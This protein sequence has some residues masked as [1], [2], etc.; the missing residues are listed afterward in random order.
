[1]I[2]LDGEPCAL[3][4][5][6]DITDAKQ[7]EKARDASEER[8]RLAQQVARIGTFE[9]DIQTGVNTWTQELEAIYGLPPG[10]FG[11]T[12]TAFKSLVYP[13]DRPGVI[14]LVDRSLKTGQPTQGEWRVVW[15]DGSIHWIAGRWQVF[16]NES[17]EPSRMIG[18]N[19]DITERKLAEEALAGVGRR[20]I[21]AQERERT[22]IGRDLHD[23]INQ[24]LAALQI[25][26][27]EL[28]Q[29]PRE[30][31]ANLQ[32][33][34]MEI[35]ARVSDIGSDVQAISHRLHSSKLEYL[36]LVA[37]CKGFCNELAD[38]QKVS[39]DFEAEDVPRRMP[40]DV[41]LTLFRVLQESLQNA[42][43]HSGSQHF[44]VQ[45]HGVSGEIQLT[46][47]DNG[48]GF[49]VDAAMN[50][51][52]LGLISMRERVSLMK[53]TI[54]IA[55]KPSRGTEINVRVPINVIGRAN[56]ATSGAA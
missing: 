44:Q 6:A 22:R 14:E 25:D 20:L 53:G 27:D 17:G 18:V 34:L 1:L 52:G 45:L 49:D 24:R 33:R 30:T 46:I 13:D 7:A 3:S 11:A 50:T 16:M 8:L 28:G 37:A 2:D 35:G 54:L 40:Y 55:S 21:Q 5:I 32:A 9:W 31:P 51:H 56:E 42:I 38:R 26:L 48:I 39:V 12:Q 36:G 4:L 15:R 41:S 23:D 10:G 29:F 43:K 19:M 47:R